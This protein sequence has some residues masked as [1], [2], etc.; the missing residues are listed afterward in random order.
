L[1]REAV[2]TVPDKGLALQQNWVNTGNGYC[3]NNYP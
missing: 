3:S 1:S 2:D